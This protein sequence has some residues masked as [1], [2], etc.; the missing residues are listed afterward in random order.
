MTSAMRRPPRSRLTPPA[1]S[2]HPSSRLTHSVSGA[3]TAHLLDPEAQPG[4]GIVLTA[5][6]AQR[7]RPLAVGL[8]APWLVPLVPEQAAGA[9]EAIETG[10]VRADPEGQHPH[11]GGVGLR[12]AAVA[13]AVA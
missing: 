1:R 7:D 2:R 9:E 12:R 10:G 5:P 3:A 11:E 6:Q 13:G 4:R 8:L